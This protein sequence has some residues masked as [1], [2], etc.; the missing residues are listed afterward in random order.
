MVGKDWSVRVYVNAILALVR[1]HGFTQRMIARGLGVS[2]AYVSRLLREP[3]KLEAYVA[4][5][6]NDPALVDFHRAARD[7]EF[8]KRL[9]LE[10][11]LPELREE[12]HPT[13]I[14]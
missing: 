9:R 7:P 2:E 13:L 11:A 14:S 8:R 5:L 3:R 1:E 4:R 6:G 10:L 12:R